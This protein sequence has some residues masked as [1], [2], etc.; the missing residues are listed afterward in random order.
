MGCVGRCG[1][2]NGR[3]DFCK[4]YPTLSDIVP[5]GCTYTFV[6][7]ER[8][9]QCIPEVCGDNNCCSYPREGGEPEAK[10]LDGFIGGLPCKHLK[11]EELEE[12][13]KEAEVEVLS[14]FTEINNLAAEVLHNVR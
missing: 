2:Y 14:L 10:T 5:P 7:G 13:E 9:G 11:W 1:A 8:L 12:M 4:N 3:P 6:G